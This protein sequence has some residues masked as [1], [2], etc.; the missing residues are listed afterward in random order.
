MPDDG[1]S[2]TELAKCLMAV[3]QSHD[4][5]A[6]I[7]LFQHYAPRLTTYFRGLGISPSMADDLVQETMLRLWNK[8][9]YFDPA[10]G[11]PSAWV[12]TIARNL[13]RT[14]KLRERRF[15]S[16]EG[17]LL[18]MEDPALGP[19]R[20]LAASETASR[21]DQVLRNLSKEDADLLKASFLEQKSHT[22][23]ARERNRPLGTVKSRLRRTLARLRKALSELT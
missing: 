9:H 21:L 3:G 22:N 12:F 6:F 10:R 23:I 14:T 20:L 19:D 4:R 2:A 8:A 15:T 18:T 7:T 1:R 13:L 17:D 5:T 16:I 11:P